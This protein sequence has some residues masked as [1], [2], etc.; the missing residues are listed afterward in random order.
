MKL[1]YASIA[2]LCAF[3]NVNAQKYDTITRVRVTATKIPQT[4][5]E[6][7]RNISII[8]AYDIANSTATSFEE[9]LRQEAGI[10]INSRGG[11][12]VQADIGIRG[13]TFSQV[14]IMVDNMRLNDPLT[15]HFNHIL[16]VA[17][18][19]IG[20]IEVI[21]GPAAVAY[22]S[23]AVGG[24]IHIKTHSYLNNFVRDTLTSVGSL[25]YGSNNYLGTDLNI[26][27]KRKKWHIGF[28][29]QINY[30]TGE[31][32]LNPNFGKNNAADSLFG[33]DFNLQQYS[34]YGSYSPTD[35]L[36]V[37]AR[38]GVNTRDFNAKYFYTASAFDESREVVNTLWSQVSLI[39]YK[40]INGKHE[41]LRMS[42]LQPNWELNLG[43]RRTQ[44]EFDFNPLFTANKHT[45]TKMALNAN[46][47]FQYKNKAWFSAGLQVENRQIESTDRGDHQNLDGGLYLIMNTK[48]R[49]KTS[50]TFGN[51]LAYNTNFDFVYLPQLALSHSVRKNLAIQGSIG[52]SIRA[53][54]FTEKYINYNTALIAANRNV[55]NP[56]L[57]NEQSTAFDFGFRYR[58]KKWH[59]FAASFFQRNSTNVIDYVNTLGQEIQNLTNVSDSNN[60]LYTRNIANVNTNGLEVSYNTRVLIDGLAT[61]LSLGLNYTYFNTYNTENVISKYIT[62][63]PKHTLNGMIRFHHNQLDLV[64]ETNYIERTANQL[65]AIGGNVRPNY[66][67]VNGKIAYQIS[68][69]V[70]LNFRVLNI[71]DEQ[72]QEILGSPMPG[73]WFMGGLSWRL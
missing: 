5:E 49:E 23:D 57:L 1:F 70:H 10:N 34:L 17:L 13:A 29:N 30:S 52:K 69:I 66:L 2:F 42:P 67:I 24:L 62:N 68:P 37:L 14:L 41:A 46:K 44:D 22:G 33:T 16:P 19:E 72:Y 45:M 28:A 55:G 50:I 51:R 31:T 36:R 64:F 32:F 12:G 6:S 18:S 54:D 7:G 65:V 4:P 43:L 63:H 9:L 56:D 61:N 73:R 20:W 21:R 38:A 35:K 27:Y 26:N 71:M 58:L 11:F 40:H 53:A 39:K 3:L 47:R 59:Q 48:V 60:Y 15:G 25:N 8:T